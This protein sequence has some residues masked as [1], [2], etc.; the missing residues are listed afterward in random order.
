MAHHTLAKMVF[1]QKKHS[2]ATLNSICAYYLIFRLSVH[3]MLGVD[4]FA[5]KWMYEL[6][7]HQSYPYVT[8]FIICRNYL[9]FSFN[10]YHKYSNYVR[11]GNT[12]H[13]FMKI[14]DSLGF[15]R[16]AALLVGNR[17]S[18]IHYFVC[19]NIHLYVPTF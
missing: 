1:Q 18:I 5:A 19:S 13:I 4:D 8:V 17:L 14:Y 6:K 12:F 9:F 7:P 2:L 10:V 15:T 11:H 16:E 3:Y